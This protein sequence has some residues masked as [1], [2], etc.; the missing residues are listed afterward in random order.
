MPMREVY[1]RVTIGQ[2]LEFKGGIQP[3]TLIDP[4][5]TPEV[6][7]DHGTPEE[8]RKQFVAHVLSEDPSAAPGTK[9]VYSNASYAVLAYVAAQATGKS[10]EQLMSE[11]IFVPLKMKSA[12]FGRPYSATSRDQPR[13]HFQVDGGWQP[14][15]EGFAHPASLSAAGDVSASMPDFAKF[16]AEELRIAKGKSRILSR[17]TN[18]LLNQTTPLAEGQTL[19][20]GAGTFTASLTLWPSLDLA[21]V[22]AINGGRSEAVCREVS[23]VLVTRGGLTG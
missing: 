10:W 23:K 20:G 2:L 18:A 5:R 15:P 21:A 6:F 8:Q 14:E 9:V 13:G 4:S 1:E 22:A 7:S 19:L 12:G 17:A 11:N 3:Y 16:A